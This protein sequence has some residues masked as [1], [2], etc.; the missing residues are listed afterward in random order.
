LVIACDSGESGADA[1]IDPL[2][3]VPA[4]SQTLAQ[5]FS[6]SRIAAPAPD[7]GGYRAA[8]SDERT[9]L[10]ESMEMILSGSGGEGVLRAI[11]ADY[12]VCRDQRV[13]IWEPTD[14]GTGRA[15][16]A[17]R[18]DATRGLIVE[19]P[20]AVY[21][22]TT[23]EES[24]ALFDGI[25]ARA[26]VASGTHRCANATAS[27]CDGTTGACGEREDY[28]ESDM[29]HA[30]DTSFQIAHEVLSTEHAADWIVSV[31]GMG[32]LGASLSDGTNMATTVDAPVALLVAAMIAQFPAEQITTCN[33]HTGAV[34]NERLC[35]TT[36]TQGRFTN[37]SNAT[38]TVGATAAS[39]RF[40]HMEQSS[41]VRA[42]ADSVVAAFDQV[43]PSL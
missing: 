28:R 39:G 18:Q 21:D 43:V 30:T 11:D 31:H 10:G 2:N 33:A 7:S 24:V 27:G 17:W 3:G 34:F 37:G 8:T 41:E 5:V 25:S 32:D 40:I 22:L 14:R 1:A 16:I 12:V 29:A 38:C 19:A 15:V 26:L 35:G 20:H 13:V 36:N 23:L 42:A 4:C 6:P 9:A